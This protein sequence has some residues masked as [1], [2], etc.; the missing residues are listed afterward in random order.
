MNCKNNILLILFISFLSAHVSYSQNVKL[1][2]KSKDS[3]QDSVDLVINIIHLDSNKGKVFVALHNTKKTWLK[4]H[5]KGES[6]IITENTAV[7]TFKQ[8]P[9]GTYAVSS[10]HDKNNNGKLDTNFMGI[11]KEPYACSNNTKPAFSAPK[12]KKA[13]FILDQSTELTIKY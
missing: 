2:L 11:P 12:W 13:K 6:A 8:I 9:S 10:F 1:E 5:Y 4:E 7:F 3:K